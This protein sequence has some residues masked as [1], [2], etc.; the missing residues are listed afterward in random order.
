M[1]LIVLV[2]FFISSTVTLE[3]KKLKEISFCKMIKYNGLGPKEVGVFK[4]NQK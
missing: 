3:I 1:N 4:G 2:P